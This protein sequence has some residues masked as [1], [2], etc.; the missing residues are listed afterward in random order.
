ME[1]R[2][3]LALVGTLQ[4]PHDLSCPEIKTEKFKINQSGRYVKVTLDS[5]YGTRGTALQYVDVSFKRPCTGK[6]RLAMNQ[7]EV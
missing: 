5:S 7:G 3:H 2:W 4:S 6:N 1:D